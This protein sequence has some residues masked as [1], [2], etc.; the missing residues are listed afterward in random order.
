MPRDAYLA[1]L[2]RLRQD[3]QD[4]FGAEC[5]STSNAISRLFGDHRDM[6]ELVMI[7]AQIRRLLVAAY[8]HNSA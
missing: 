3:R 2:D 1:I 5:M 4:I 6:S 7:K 8:L